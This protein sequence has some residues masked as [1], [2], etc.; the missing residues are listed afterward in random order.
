M[1]KTSNGKEVKHEKIGKET[2]NT[3]WV[4]GEQF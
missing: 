1:R 4:P 3:Y 2:Q